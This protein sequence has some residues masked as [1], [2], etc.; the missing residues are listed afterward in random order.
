MSI[1]ANPEYLVSNGLLQVRKEKQ[2]TQDETKK[3]RE[4]EE[5]KNCGADFTKTMNIARSYWGL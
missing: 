4:G 2:I 1:R 3:N 5:M